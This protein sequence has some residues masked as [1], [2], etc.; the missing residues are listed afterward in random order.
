MKTVRLSYYPWITQHI[1]APELDKQIRR[2]AG[3]LGQELATIIAE[4]TTIEILPPIDVPDQI[5]Q[6]VSGDAD[7]ALMNPI[8]Y[9]FAHRRDESIRA[10]AVAQR[11]IDGKIGT[12]YF[13]Q[14]YTNK[15]T[16]ISE[17]K[18]AKGRSLAFGA[19]FSTSNFLVP[20]L[21]LKNRR[22]HPLTAFSTVSYLG[23]HDKVAEAVYE[24][25][26]DVGA[27]HDGVIIDL[28]NQD[29]YRDAKECLLQLVRSAPIPSDPIVLRS[30]D[31]D[32]AGKITEALVAASKTDEGKES[33]AIFWG[34]VVGLEAVDPAVYD[35][36]ASALN[37]LSLS[38]TD[39]LV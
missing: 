35:V 23:G 36:L 1:S 28:S 8:G 20:A 6:L 39:I 21:E 17:I 15:R 14:L 3:L 11:V 27:G 30:P 13:A 37:S 16:G 4:P 9:V 34:K 25:R 19:K 24:G 22:L 12:T 2:F 38:E 31:K 26:A 32:W 7:L 10:I 29:G 33:L 18:Q 5:K